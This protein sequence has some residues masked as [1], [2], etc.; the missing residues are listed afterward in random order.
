MNNV[1]TEKFDQMYS[2]LKEEKKKR[3]RPKKIIENVEPQEKQEI[4]KVS[5]EEAQ[6]LTDQIISITNQMLINADLKPI[7]PAQEMLIRLG[8]SGCIIKYGIS[9]DQYP[10]ILLAGGVA[11]CAWDKYNEYRSKHD[12]NN[13]GK[14]GNRK[15][16][17][18][19]T[20]IEKE[21]KTESDNY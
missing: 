2:E 19:K 13:T 20:D 6:N 10:E 12:H 11:W 18:S 21:D 17:I 15:N 16:N 14:E 3:G 7:N 4:P 9:L 5:I 1:D 8:L